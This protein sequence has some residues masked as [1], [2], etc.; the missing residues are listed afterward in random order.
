MGDVIADITPAHE[1]VCVAREMVARA[2]E[3]K[4]AA[5][6]LVRKDGSIWY[7]MTGHERASVLWALQ[8]MIHELMNAD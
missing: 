3:A 7:D 8:K 5:A 2:P 4:A 6:V 1:P